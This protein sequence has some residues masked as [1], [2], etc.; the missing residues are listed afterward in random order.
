MIA[1]TRSSFERCCGLQTSMTRSSAVNAGTLKT[2]GNVGRAERF[3]GSQSRAPSEIR[4]T[5]SKH[6]HPFLP[7]FLS[8]I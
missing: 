5:P 7:L 3:C 6:T 1:R 2:G 4:L 8:Y